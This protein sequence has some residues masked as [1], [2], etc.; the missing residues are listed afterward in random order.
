MDAHGTGGTPLVS[1][2]AVEAVRFYVAGGEAEGA[3]AADVRGT[4]LGKPDAPARGGLLDLMMGTTSAKVDCETCYRPRQRCVG[5]RGT[6]ALNAPVLEALFAKTVVQWLKAVCHECGALLLPRAAEA[7]Q[8]ARGTAAA[9]LRWLGKEIKE[10]HREAC[11]QCQRPNQWHLLLSEQDNV[12]ILRRG[13]EDTEHRPLPT[14]AA[15]RILAALP[16]EDAHFMGLT[17][18]THPA[19]MILRQVAV[20][21]APLR[22]PQEKEGGRLTQDDITGILQMVLQ[23][24]AAVAPEQAAAPD[25]VQF[26]Q[27]QKLGLLLRS[28]VKV[29]SE[30]Q[31]SRVMAPVDKSKLRIQTGQRGSQIIP[32]SGRLG[33]KHGHIRGAQMGRRSNYQARAVIANDP[34]LPLD[35]IKIPLQI[36]TVLQAEEVVSAHNRGFLADLLQNGRARYPGCTQIVRRGAAYSADHV[37]PDFVLEHGDVVYRDLINGDVVMFNRMPS[38]EWSAGTTYKVLVDTTA[39]AEFVILMNVHICVLHN[40]D[41]DGDQMSIWCAPGAAARAEIAVMSPAAKML[42]SP[43]DVKP[44]MGGTY[45][46]IIGAARLCMAPELSRWAAMLVASSVPNPP[47]FPPRTAGGTGRAKP[48]EPSGEVLPAGETVSG[49]EIV[50]RVLPPV[51]LQMKTKLSDPTLAAHVDIPES[52]KHLFIREGTVEAG[53]LDKKVAGEGA[54]GG[55]YH[56]IA[57]R[58]G[59]EAALRTIFAVMQLSIG[60]LSRCGHTMSLG[61]LYVPR[62]GQARLHQIAAGVRAEIAMLVEQL[63][64]GRVVAPVGQTVGEF[65]EERLVAAMNVHSDALVT[66]LQT[67]DAARNNFFQLIATGA[68]GKPANYVAISG[69]GGAVTVNA[70]LNEMNGSY[71]RLYPWTQRFDYSTRGFVANSILN[72]VTFHEMIE[73]SRAGRFALIGKALLTSVAGEQYRNTAKNTE[74]VLVD[75][76]GRLVEG[77]RVLCSLYGNTGYDPRRLVEVK[78]DEYWVADAEFAA[79]WAYTGARTPRLARALAAAEAALREARD[80]FR[81]RA[82]AEEAGE[83]LQPA[84]PRAVLPLNVKHLLLSLVRAGAAAP[85]APDALAGMLEAAD[86][87]VRRLPEFYTAPGC[88]PP[89]PYRA[90]AALFAAHCRIALAPANLARA[91]PEQLEQAL[92]QTRAGVHRALISPGTAVGTIAAQV[93]GEPF[94]QY[95]LDSMHNVAGG[96]TSRDVA[97]AVKALLAASVSYRRAMHVAPAAGV[98]AQVLANHVELTRVRRFVAHWQVF[99]EPLGGARHPAYRHENA[100]TA[101]FLK[102]NRANPPPASLIAA[103]VRIEVDRVLMMM[104]NTQIEEVA[105]VVARHLPKV[106]V[107][108]TPETAPGP[109]VLRAYPAGEYFDRAGPTKQALVALKEKILNLPV[110]G[111]V[112]VE[113]ARVKTV[114]RTAAGADGAMA[115]RGVEVVAT[116][117]SNL[118]AVLLSP[119]VDSVRTTTTSTWDAYTVFGAVAAR[120][121]VESGIME[122]GDGSADYYHAHR[123]V[124]SNLIMT[125]GEPVSVLTGIA[126]RNPS[127]VLLAAS[128]R[129]ALQVFAR[130]A[131]DGATDPCLD[132]AAATMLG[133]TPRL[134]TNYSRLEVDEEALRRRFPDPLALLDQ[135]AGA[136]EDC[137]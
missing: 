9:R 13:P 54:Q 46:T 33:G 53:V 74:A 62:R 24:N 22:P 91:A 130:A 108:W 30:K 50:S 97:S 5:H 45:D 94:T 121:V 59:P 87:F 18:E 123:Q 84:R 71:K 128:H 6:I 137:V 89:A 44:R 112:G 58:Y 4:E 48:G 86:A 68:K 17:P 136:C 12:T 125:R 21:P 1:E 60:F 34:T 2:G 23:H 110:H 11:W 36:A 103:C 61:D 101:A 20:L 126:E 77:G 56:T 133:Q 39:T 102:A 27:H 41:F 29:G 131:Q 63:A 115:A 107:V 85:P 106:Y 76:F 96:G 132:P 95:M 118:Q 32:L 65:F 75:H 55:L 113:E 114:Q 129:S 7:R 19:R 98:P 122:A 111:V 134:G 35:T 135:V 92:Q 51:N 25:P 70:R 104:R 100:H 93:F 52:A 79:L 10:S 40:A 73:G 99:V 67:V 124:Y 105:A 80:E 66:V 38:L 119:E 42:I 64:E 90:G 120:R 43:R 83:H 57:N 3:L 88:A 72:G 117:G 69:I 37:P 28:M 15:R 78:L 49:R 8:R 82:L 109:L 31:Q 81:A 127:A 116:S 16:D 14:E 26:E 47:R